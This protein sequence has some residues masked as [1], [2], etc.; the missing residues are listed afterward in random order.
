MIFFSPPSFRSGSKTEE[1]NGKNARN[2][3]TCSGVLAL[4]CRPTDYRRLGPCPTVC[5][6]RRCSALQT[7]DGAWPAWPQ[8]KYIII[9]FTCIRRA[10]VHRNCI[11]LTFGFKR[12][13]V[14]ISNTIIFHIN[15]TN[16]NYV[17]H[18]I[19]FNLYAK[20]L[21]ERIQPAY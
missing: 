7:P 8:V 19:L 10:E 21:I 20:Y 16:D 3:Q 6:P 12:F 15:L 5:V 14:F 11:L 17:Q 18:C 9:R 1:Q 2:R 13:T 4:C